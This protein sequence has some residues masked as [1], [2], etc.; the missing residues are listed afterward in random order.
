ML[1]C[2]AL[3]GDNLGRSHM[4]K[5]GGVQSGIYKS[6]TI[7]V[8]CPT[9]TERQR[10]ADLRFST[11]CSPMWD[12]MLA[13]SFPDVIKRIAQRV[14]EN[15]C[16]MLYESH[17]T[18]K[19]KLHRYLELP[20]SW[21]VGHPRVVCGSISFDPAQP[22]NPPTDW[23]NATQST[24]RRKISTQSDPT[25]PAGWQN[26]WTPLGHPHAQNFAGGVRTPA[27]GG[28]RGPTTVA[29]TV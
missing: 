7:F 11:W 12:L 19:H 15:D 14:R 25:Q 9:L 3:S 16:K 20:K 18:S 2:I 29:G 17:I 10:S 13:T 27:R 22:N 1:Y 5:T 23:P 21:G 26:P 24:K 28:A 8:P 6:H 4:I